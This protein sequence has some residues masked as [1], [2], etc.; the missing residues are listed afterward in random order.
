[1]RAN[2]FPVRTYV[3]AGLLR[4]APSARRH[5]PLF[6]FLLPLLVTGLVYLALSTVAHRAPPP[7]RK[8]FCV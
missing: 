5:A 6:F 3:V 4:H 8:A 7:P 1:M 2:M